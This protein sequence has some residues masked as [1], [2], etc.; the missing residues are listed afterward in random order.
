MSSMLLSMEE[1][2]GGEIVSNLCS[3]QAKE[4]QPHSLLGGEA[5]GR[6]YAPPT[7]WSRRSQRKKQVPANES[8]GEDLSPP[9]PQ[10][11][12]P[13]RSRSHSPSPSTSKLGP[14]P[15]KM[16]VTVRGLGGIMKQVTARHCS[17]S[18][19]HR[20]PAQKWCQGRLPRREKITTECSPSSQ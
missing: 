10:P 19:Y 7:A 8:G 15:R 12:G 2:A 14:T 1:S 9:A 11:P 17:L 13:S 4:S 18:G 16:T 20:F 3:F 6:G 5:V